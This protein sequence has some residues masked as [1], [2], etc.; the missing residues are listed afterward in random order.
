MLFNS[1]LFIFLFL[2]ITW[3]V[4]F[5]LNR[6]KLI[7]LS[8]GWL[9]VASL[10]YYSYWNLKYLPLI[11][12]SIFFNYA[13]T[14]QMLDE[15]TEKRKKLLF[16]AGLIF[17]LGLL[18]YF[19]YMGFF[20]ENISDLTG[21]QFEAIKIALP[22]GISFYTLQQI[23]YLVDVFQ[24]AATGERRLLE[25]ALFVVFFPHLLAGPI[26]HY[27]QMMPQYQS[28]KLKVFSKRNIALGIFIFVIGLSKKVII[29]DT[30]S[31]WVNEAFQQTDKLHLFYAWGTSLAYTLQLY[32]DFSGYS[33]MAIGIGLLFNFQ[34]PQNFNSPLRAGNINDFW[35]KWHMTLTAFIRT[36]IFTPI[37]KLLPKNFHYSMLAMILAMTIAG[38]WHGA[39]WTYIVYGILHGIAIV[40]HYYWKKSKRKLPHFWGWFLT[41]NFVNL[42]FIIFRANSL[43]EAFQVMKGMIGLNGI[44]IPKLGIGPLTTL[45]NYLEKKPAPY[46]TN[47]ENMQLFLIVL[48]FL[49]ITKMD[50]SSYWQQNFEPKTKLAFVTAVMFVICLFGLNRVSEFIYFNF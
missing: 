44:Q 27:D 23:A 4:Y 38:I 31:V 3:F 2:P 39:A 43:T 42:S 47:D 35:S 17:N 15:K 14:Q 20:L 48:G 21:W 16:Y 50:N 41:F 30:L 34:L 12:I 46:M 49:I 10:F 40:I 37:A 19:K 22:V 9:L 7:D 8:K 29:A 25:Y 33:D 26:V 1:Y 6:Y 45:L 36:Y 5:A 28:L 11:L 32:F 13:L 24:G 18:G